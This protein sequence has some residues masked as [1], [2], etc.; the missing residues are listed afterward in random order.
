MTNPLNPGHPCPACDLAMAPS[1]LSCTCGVRIQA[2]V[3]LN[4]FASL[5]ADHLHFL[6][7]FIM[8]EGR[9]TDIESALGVSYPTVKAKIAAL[10]DALALAGPFDEVEGILAQLESGE[11]DPDEAIRRLT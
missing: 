9:I 6:R 10:K 2:P 1:A 8:F 4:E 7:I 3:S 5:N 11:I